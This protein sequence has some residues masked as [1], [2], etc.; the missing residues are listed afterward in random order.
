MISNRI[1][2]TE[3]ILRYAILKDTST[4]AYEKLLSGENNARNVLDNKNLEV[5]RERIDILYEDGN[6][7]RAPKIDIETTNVIYGVKTSIG[8]LLVIVEKISNENGSL[9]FY[10]R[11]I[12]PTSVEILAGQ[13][14]TICDTQS[15]NDFKVKTSKNQFNNLRSGESVVFK[16]SFDDTSITDILETKIRAVVKDIRFF[17]NEKTIK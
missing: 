1:S 13:L 16:I 12:N 4:N 9:K 14:V 11:L 17:D 7:D 15:E 3:K 6:I 10:V 5:L 2:L 8:N